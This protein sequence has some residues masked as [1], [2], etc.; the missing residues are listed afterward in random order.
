MAISEDE[1]KLVNTP[2][3]KPEE[4]SEILNAEVKLNPDNSIN[5]DAK[6]R[7][8]GAQYDFQMPLT[9]LNKDEVKEA[10]KER[11]YYL[12]MENLE[13]NNVTNR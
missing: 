2:T 13:A 8:S 4:S 9:S 11:F 12:N 6:F 7:F 5:V 10:L 1:I 3:Y